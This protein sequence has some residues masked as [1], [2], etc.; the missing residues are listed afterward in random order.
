MTV[1]VLYPKYTD[2]T[3]AL[4]GTQSAEVD[5]GN[6][7]IVGIITPSTFDGTTITIQASPTSG[8][9]F[10][11]VAAANTASTAYTI[12]TT[13]S[14][15]SPIDPTVTRGLRYIKLTCGSSQTTTATVLQLV[16][17]PKS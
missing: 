5:I 3:I 13:A 2:V 4:S 8:G 12:T 7:D 10:Y 17:R 15:W 16:L 11:P 9:T 14:I 1:Q 6:Y